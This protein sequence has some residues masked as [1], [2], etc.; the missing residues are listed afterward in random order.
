MGKATPEH[1]ALLDKARRNRLGIEGYIR[2]IAALRTPMTTREVEERFG[3]NHNTACKTLAH[4]HRYK[5]IQRVEWLR[6]VAHSRW[7]PR[8]QFN[9]IDVPHPIGETPI[10]GKARNAVVLLGTVVEILRDEPRT[11]GELADELAMHEE[12]ASR[13]IGLLRKHGLSHIKS[14]IKPP[15]GVTVA[16]HAFGPGRDAKRP[17][18]TPIVIQRARHRATHAR[19]RAH[20]AMIRITAASAAELQPMAA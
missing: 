5:L 19:K 17:A 1:A 3:I 4:M 18:R 15:I 14:W 10:K 2:I 6:P 20:L 13:V 11:L 12:S 9:G 8:W 16:Q 7:L